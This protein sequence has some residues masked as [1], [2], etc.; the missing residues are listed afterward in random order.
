MN[1]NSRHKKS[2][3]SDTFGSR[4]FAT[5]GANDEA[6]PVT[7][8][9]SEEASETNGLAEVVDF[10]GRDFIITKDVLIPRPETE[11]L[12]DA[13]LSL[14]GKPYLPGVKPTKRQLPEKPI[15]MDIGTGSGCIAVTLKK[16]LPDAT[17]YATDISKPALKVTKQNANTHKADI[18]IMTSDMLAKVK[19]HEIPIP[20]L[21][22]A[23]LPYVDETWP[24]LDKPSLAK[25]PSLALYAKDHGLKLIKQLIEEASSLKIRY[26]ILES[27]P[28]QHTTIIHFA[29]KT[30]FRHLETRGFILTFCIP[31][32]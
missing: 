5:T 13:V 7:T 22:A 29:R 30:G 28:C 21:I 14:A 19:S 25:E 3:S 2:I 1:A 26:L 32:E 11:Q 12:I 4:A 6:S 31:Q 8:G 10:Y 16:E 27:D 9:A 18:T 24:W 23:N 17:I 15:I 20:D